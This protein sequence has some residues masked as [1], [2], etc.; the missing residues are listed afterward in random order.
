MPEENI[1]VILESQ[2][3]K[4]FRFNGLNYVF[5]QI[6]ESEFW[7]QSSFPEEE[8][9]EILF[10]APYGESGDWRKDVRAVES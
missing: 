3:V 8:D 10:D 2:F 6:P 1:T 4:A 5:S 7:I 9:Y